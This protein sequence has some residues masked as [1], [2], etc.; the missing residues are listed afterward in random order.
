VLVQ[1]CISNQQVNIKICWRPLLLVMHK[2]HIFLLQVAINNWVINMV[3][4]SRWRS[5]IN[6]MLSDN[7]K[8]RKS[9]TYEPKEC[10]E[11]ERIKL[12]LGIDRIWWA[13]IPFVNPEVECLCRG[14]QDLSLF[15]SRFRRYFDLKVMDWWRPTSAWPNETRLRRAGWAT[16]TELDVDLILHASLELTHKK[17]LENLRLKLEARILSH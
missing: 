7:C 11:K 9:R 5:I 3:E 8:I 17:I 10:I 14:W 12:K 1:T 2:L 13:D 6:Y 4:H 16:E 15:V